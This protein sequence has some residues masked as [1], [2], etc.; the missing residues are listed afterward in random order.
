MLPK[1]WHVPKYR[2]K[3]SP[4]PHRPIHDEPVLKAILPNLDF[5][6]F[7]HAGACFNPIRLGYAEEIRVKCISSETLK[8]L[9]PDL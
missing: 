1:R 8:Q 6:L 4:F 5:G 2:L 7:A 9:R 3:L